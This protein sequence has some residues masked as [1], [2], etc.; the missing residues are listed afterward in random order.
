MCNNTKNQRK[1]RQTKAK[2][3]INARDN[4][5]TNKTQAF[6]NALMHKTKKNATSTTYSRENK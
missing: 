1:K 2:A 5:T 6:I 4:K 3:F